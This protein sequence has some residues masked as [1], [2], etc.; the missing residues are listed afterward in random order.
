MSSDHEGLILARKS[1]GFVVFSFGRDPEVRKSCRSKMISYPPAC[2]AECLLAEV[3]EWE[4]KTVLSSAKKVH[5]RI[6]L[7]EVKIPGLRLD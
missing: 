3:K 6:L 1:E 5:G 2:Y 7:R 4:Q